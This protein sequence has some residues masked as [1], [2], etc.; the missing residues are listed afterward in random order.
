MVVP[1]R[2]SEGGTTDQLTGFY[3]ACVFE[4]TSIVESGQQ[5]LPQKRGRSGA[6]TEGRGVTYGNAALDGKHTSGWWVWHFIKPADSLRRVYALKA[7]R[8]SGRHT[9]QVRSTTAESSPSMR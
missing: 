4:P 3:D 2:G 8:Q 5:S 9:G 7:S 1:K 6:S